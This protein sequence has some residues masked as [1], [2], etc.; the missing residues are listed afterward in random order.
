MQL[1]ANNNVVSVL[2]T[3]MPVQAIASEQIVPFVNTINII[4]G[5]RYAVVA[6]LTSGTPTTSMIMMGVGNGGVYN[7]PFGLTNFGRF[8]QSKNTPFVSGDFISSVSA[9]ENAFDFRF[10]FKISGLP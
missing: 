4:S 8:L 5:V 6:I 2:A 10:F 9:G 7:T 1:D 3:S